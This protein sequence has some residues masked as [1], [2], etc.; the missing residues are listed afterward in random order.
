MYY[1]CFL[2]FYIF[3]LW[4]RIPNDD[5]IPFCYIGQSNPLS[6]VFSPFPIWHIYLMQ[7]WCSFHLPTTQ[8]ALCL[9]VRPLVPSIKNT[10]IHLGPFQVMTVRCSMSQDMHKIKFPKTKLSRLGGRN[11]ICRISAPLS[12]L[13]IAY[14]EMWV[15]IIM[16]ESRACRRSRGRIVETATVYFNVDLMDLL[17]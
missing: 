16:E 12:W 11:H 3:C 8:M 6:W 17:P 4:T 1:H 9:S 5:C 2:F 13:L 7:S 15:N 14:R 10:K